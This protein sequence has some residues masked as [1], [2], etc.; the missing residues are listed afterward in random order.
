MSNGRFAT[1]LHILTL[2]EI[3]NGELLASGYIAG[4]INVNPAVVRKEIRNLR[5]LGFV[6][7]KEGKGGGFSLGKPASAI[8]LG[9]LYRAVTY[10]PLLGR[11]NNPNP[12][13][14]V[15][16]QI[17]AHL[18]GLFKTADEIFLQQLGQITVKDFAA[19][20]T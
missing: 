20:F 6:N 15:G 8:T 5:E 10:T 12:G 14:S 17:N 1:A 2:L 19:K 18:E 4:S 3:K 11:S 16:R 13:C 9:E 7:S